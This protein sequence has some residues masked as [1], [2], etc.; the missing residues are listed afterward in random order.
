MEGGRV[1]QAMSW[2]LKGLGGEHLI[3]KLVVARCLY[4]RVAVA[5]GKGP[6][7]SPSV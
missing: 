6:S 5:L 7:S 4:T 2:E 3:A 1:P